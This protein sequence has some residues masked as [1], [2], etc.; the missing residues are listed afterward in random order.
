M[1][2]FVDVATG[3]ITEYTIHNNDIL[4]IMLSIKFDMSHV[5][6]MMRIL[7]GLHHYILSFD[8]LE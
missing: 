2:G 4:T 1:Y 6:E 5:S 7:Q 3:H 8:M